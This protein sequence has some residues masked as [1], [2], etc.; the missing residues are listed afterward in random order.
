MI[1]PNLPVDLVKKV[2]VSCDI[3]KQ[4]ENS[5]SAYGIKSYKLYGD[6]KCDE[7]VK[8][9]PDMYLLHFSED[10]IFY[11]KN[12]CSVIGESDLNL[13]YRGIQPLLD[14]S[15]TIEYPKD[16]FLNSVVLGNRI[17]C[18]RKFLHQDALEFALQNNYDIIN[19]NQGYTK[20]SICV[21]NENSIITEDAGIAKT[22]SDF[23]FDI[24]FLENHSVMLPGY[25]YGFIGGASG[26]S[27][28]DRLAFFGDI[29][30]HPEYNNILSFLIK[31]DVEPISLSHEPLL[32]LG[33]LIPFE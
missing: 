23:G 5:L 31:H 27:S 17:I 19:V 2:I 8:N 30:K 26:K 25:K 15:E 4:M 11:A 7:A 29:R 18:N 22:L 14:C 1:K 3:T 32:D 28:Q 33:S 9:H 12:I 6:M 24:L 21:V 20:C 13:N 16:V 10:L